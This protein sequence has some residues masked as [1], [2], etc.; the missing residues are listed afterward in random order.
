LVATQIHGDRIADDHHRL[1]PGDVLVVEGG[2]TVIAEFADRAGCSVD[3]VASG[4]YDK[5]VDR[6]TG[7]AELL[8]PPRSGTA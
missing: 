7:L 5:L 8:I 3:G 1:E 6:D 2:D 4:S